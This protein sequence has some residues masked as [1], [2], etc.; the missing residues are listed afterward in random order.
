MFDDMNQ[1]FKGRGSLE[2]ILPEKLLLTTEEYAQGNKAKVWHF[3]SRFETIFTLNQD[4][5][6]EHLYLSQPE[7]RRAVKP[8]LPGLQRLKRA[9]AQTGDSWADS[10]WIPTNDQHFALSE[11]GQPYIKL[12]GSSNWYAEDGRRVLIIGGA[13]QQEIGTFPILREYLSNF[14]SALM[15]PKSRLMVI[16][17]GFRDNHVN[18]VLEKAITSGL[19]IFVIDPNGA[20][21]AFKL[22]RT[23][24]SST[25][26]VNTSLE[27]MLKKAVIG[28]SRRRLADIFGV[29]R[30]EFNKILR[31]FGDS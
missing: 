5:L 4:L 16:G 13:K 31:F 21:L 3:L 17:Y 27:M 8:Q 18:D 23:R 9:G 20:E 28:G 12:H 26:A 24:T 6:L 1:A 22:N 14:E 25:I 2:F 19:R 30:M 15:R 7:V 10:D 11:G 29:D